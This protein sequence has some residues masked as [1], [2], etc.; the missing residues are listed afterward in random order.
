[1]TVGRTARTAL[2]LAAAGTLA[3]AARPSAADP[4]AAPTT[5]PVTKPADV[6]ITFNTDE[7]PELKD[8]AEKTLKPVLVEWYPRI[9]AELPIPRREP[10]TQFSI[11]FTNSYKGVAATAGTHVVANTKWI[12]DNLKG[13]SVGALLHEEVHVVQQPYQPHGTRHPTYMPSWVCEGTCDYVRWFEFEPV[14]KRRPLERGPKPRYDGAYHPS[15]QFLKYVAEHYDKQIMAELNEASYFGKYSD[16]LW[17]QHTG[18][19]VEQLGSEW[20]KSIGGTGDPHPPTTQPA[21]RRPT[22]AAATRPFATQ[23]AGK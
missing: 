11:R 16:D 8:W 23:P 13:E 7:A 17:K 6:V 10:P 14:G 21:R 3:W 5:G 19:T 4:T 15:G 9:A 1:M 12:T 18:K 20:E 2:L 22:T